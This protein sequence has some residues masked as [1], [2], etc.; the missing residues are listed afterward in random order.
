MLD[1]RDIGHKQEFL[2]GVSGRPQSQDMSACHVNLID[3][4]IISDFIERFKMNTG[5]SF[6]WS[7]QKLSE[8]IFKTTLSKVITW[9][10][11]FLSVCPLQAIDM[12]KE[13]IL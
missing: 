1:E 8:V 6:F 3:A 2:C 10:L 7:L 12:K 5:Y 9:I 13:I 11:T 4:T